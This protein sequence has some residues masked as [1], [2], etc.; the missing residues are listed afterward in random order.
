MGINEIRNR[1]LSRNDIAKINAMA[2]VSVEDIKEMDKELTDGQSER[3]F[4]HGLPSPVK[5]ST[6]VKEKPPVEDVEFY[7]PRVNEFHQFFLNGGYSHNEAATLALAAATLKAA[8]VIGQAITDAHS[9]KIPAIR[10]KS[11]IPVMPVKKKRGRPR[12]VK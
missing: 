5:K 11:E 6:A 10:A 9:I 8:V 7:G 12:K 4:L 3:P 2:G 1:T